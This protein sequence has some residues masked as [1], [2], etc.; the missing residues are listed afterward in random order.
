MQW[1]WWCA[2]HSSRRKTLKLITYQSGDNR[3][4]IDY[5][6]VRKTDRCLVKDVNVIS[7]EAGVPQHRMV[8]GRLVLPMNPQKKKIVK[9]VPTPRVWNLKDEETPPAFDTIDHDIL[10]SRLCNVYGITG[11]ALDWFRSYLTGRIQRVVIEDSVSFHR[12]AGLWS[13]TWF[14]VGSEN[15]LHV[16]QTC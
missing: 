12:G 4:M 1:A 13:S 2:T 6:M 8:I 16:H 10:L 3:S 9:F 15:L 11:N 14:C 7:S 5:L